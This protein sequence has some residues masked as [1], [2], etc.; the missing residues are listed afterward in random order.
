MESFPG[1]IANAKVCEA[2]EKEMCSAEFGMGL[3]EVWELGKAQLERKTGN[4]AFDA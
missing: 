2:F 3:I 1:A 4:L